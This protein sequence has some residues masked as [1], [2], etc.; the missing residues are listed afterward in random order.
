MHIEDIKFFPLISIGHG[1]VLLKLFL[2]LCPPA[3]SSGLHAL[4]QR[5]NHSIN[6]GH[7]QPHP[8]PQQDIKKFFPGE[9]LIEITREQYNEL[10]DKN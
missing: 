5:C 2:F 8:R 10:V 1:I 4:S 7:G 3:T 6:Y 9:Y